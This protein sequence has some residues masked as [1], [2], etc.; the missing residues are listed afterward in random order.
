M[1]AAQA[2]SV[3]VLDLASLGVNGHSLLR[4]LK[5]EAPSPNAFQ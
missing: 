3:I 4:A 2:P 1:I 5:A